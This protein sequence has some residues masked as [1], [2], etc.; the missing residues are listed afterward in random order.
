[1]LPHVSHDLSGLAAALRFDGSGGDLE[2]H[3]L[4]TARRAR[5]VV[6]RVFY[7]EE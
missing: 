3:Y 5:A 4:R 6:D 7:G 1:M 2:D